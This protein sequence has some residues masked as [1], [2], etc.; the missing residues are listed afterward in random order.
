MTTDRLQV[1]RPATLA[2]PENDRPDTVRLHG[3]RA[4]IVEDE[5]LTQMQLRKILVAGGLEVVGAAGDGRSA[6]DLVLRERPDIVLMDIHM[7]EMNGLDATEQIL[8]SVRVCVV[9]LTAYSD[10]G[11]RERAQEIGASGYL[12]K[13]ITAS[14]LLPQIAQAF[15]R[16]AAA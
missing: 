5:G 2:E 7:P 15:G 10:E 14:I 12:I 11:C 13:P 9:M 3:C 1:M 8:T 16:F 4:V 6:V